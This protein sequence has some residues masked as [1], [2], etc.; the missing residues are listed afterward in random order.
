MEKQRLPTVD[1]PVAAYNLIRRY[2][3]ENDISSKGEAV[4]RLLAESPSLKRLAGKRKLDDVFD[5]GDWG[6][7][8]R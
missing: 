3:V 8:R 5:A 1:I 4:R 6:G 7:N 2:M